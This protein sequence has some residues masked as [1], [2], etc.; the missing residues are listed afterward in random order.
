[1][2][3]AGTA[4]GSPPMMTRSAYLPGSSVPTVSSH[5]LSHDRVAGVQLQ[6]FV[7]REALAGSHD[8]AGRRGPQHRVAQGEPHVRSD[9][10][11]VGRA[12]HAE[13]RT[14]QRA[15]RIEELGLIAER[16]D[17][18][19]RDRGEEPGLRH[20][21]N[22]DPSGPFKER[23]QQHSAVFDAMAQRVAGTAPED[24]FEGGEERVERAI[25]LRMDGDLEAASLAAPDDGFHRIRVAEQHAAPVR[26]DGERPLDGRGA[27]AHPAVGEDLHGRHPEARPV[28][29]EQ[30]VGRGVD[31]AVVH[32]RDDPQRQA[33]HGVDVTQGQHPAE[34]GQVGIHDRGHALGEE[35]RRGGA[36]RLDEAPRVEGAEERAGRLREDPEHRRFEDATVGSTGGVAAEH[37]ERR[38]VRGVKA[39]RAQCP[40]VENA[41]VHG[42][43]IQDARLVGDGGVE[44]VPR[45]EAALRDTRLR[46]AVAGDPAPGQAP[47]ARGPRQRI[48]DRGD[49][50]RHPRRAVH[51]HPEVRHRPEVAMRVHEPGQD[52]GA[53]EVDDARRRRCDAANL[54]VGADRTDPIALQPQG[55][56]PTTGVVHRDDRAAPKDDV[57]G[58]GGLK[59]H[60]AHLGKI[61]VEASATW[62]T[63]GAGVQAWQ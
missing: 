10:R 58:D 6:G 60:C 37:A 27:A 49:G 7:G 9:D 38:I 62:G 23:R 19:V 20:D 61:C 63:G 32:H 57:G 26:R 16:L 55:I 18:A 25:A 50:R 45:D 2:A 39:R 24:A 17:P 48:E 8:D 34:P 43:V 30:A 40:R 29:P 47:G 28:R 14:P 3:S 12:T 44:L 54:V 5:Q 41:R 42:P 11:G 31:V 35:Q 46:E 51:R 56:D 22:P 13:A 1:M 15:E 36:D 59:M 4:V 33:V 52:H 21:V 53:I